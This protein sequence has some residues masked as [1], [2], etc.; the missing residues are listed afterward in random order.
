MNSTNPSSVKART[1]VTAI[2]LSVMSS[3]AL[4]LY[5]EWDIP[6]YAGCQ[7]QTNQFPATCNRTAVNTVDTAPGE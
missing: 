5:R 1:P 4:V 2:F 3:T 6:L 7:Q